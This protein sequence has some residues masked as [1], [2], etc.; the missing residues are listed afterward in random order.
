MN[1]THYDVGG[2]FQKLCV[3]RRQGLTSLLTYAKDN[4]Q[5]IYT[6]SLITGCAVAPALC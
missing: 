5:S 2:P 4:K 1:H 6:L 3:A